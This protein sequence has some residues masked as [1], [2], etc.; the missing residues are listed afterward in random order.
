MRKPQQKRPAVRFAHRVI[1][2]TPLFCAKIESGVTVNS[3]ETK[4]PMPSLC[5]RDEEGCASQLG[6]AEQHGEGD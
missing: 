5:R 6:K 1:A 2:I 3:A 4:P